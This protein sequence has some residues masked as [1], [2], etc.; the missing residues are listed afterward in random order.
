MK[1]KTIVPL[2]SED[3]LYNLG[4]ITYSIGYLEWGLLGDLVKYDDILPDKLKMSYLVAQSTGQIADLLMNEKY[5]SLVCDDKLRKRMREFG[6]AL[7]NIVKTRN[8]VMHAHPTTFPDGEQ[9]LYRWTKKEQMMIDDSLMEKLNDSIQ[10]AIKK[11]SKMRI[12]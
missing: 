9:G 12:I 6:N 1:L 10:E 11:D 5:L 7:K 4:V 2:P 8:S 3:Y